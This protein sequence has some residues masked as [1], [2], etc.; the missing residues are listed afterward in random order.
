MR[1]RILRY[2]RAVEQLLN[3]P[4]PGTDWT[5]VKQA[6]LQQLAFFQ[7]E[8]LIHLIVTMTFAVL[9]LLSAGIALLTEF[10]FLFLL[11]A[12]LLVLLIPYIAHYYLLENKVQLMYEQYD[13]MQKLS[14]QMTLL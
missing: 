13:R 11:T 9:T 1:K 7:H 4:P 8:R 2:C 5:A 3:A 12:A 10:V 6:H 14:G